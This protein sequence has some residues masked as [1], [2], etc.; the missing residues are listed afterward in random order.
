MVAAD[1]HNVFLNPDEFADKRTVI[2]DGETYMDIPVVLTNS[3]SVIAGNSRMTMCR[4]S[5]W[6]PIR[7]TLPSVTLAVCYPKRVCGSR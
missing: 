4:D 5:I 7:S 2:Y 6:Y 3:K 1:I